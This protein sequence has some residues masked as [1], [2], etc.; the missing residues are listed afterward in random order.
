VAL[1]YSVPIIQLFRV[2]AETQVELIAILLL[3]IPRFAGYLYFSYLG[4]KDISRLEGRRRVVLLGMAVFSAYLLLSG[5]LAVYHYLIHPEHLMVAKKFAVAI[6]F[7][8]KTRIGLSR[9]AFTLN[10]F[11]LAGIFLYN[12]A[13]FTIKGF[14]IENQLRMMCSLLIAIG[15][16]NILIVS[17]VFTPFVG[18]LAL[19]LALW[20]RE[21]GYKLAFLQA[22]LLALTS[23]GIGSGVFLLRDFFSPGG[24]ERVFMYAMACCLVVGVISLVGYI[25]I[26][27]R[28]YSRLGKRNEYRAR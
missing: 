14:T 10:S 8:E 12:I 16:A 6:P 27:K 18:F 11:V 23:A 25:A 2:R 20:T 28:F 21:K 15:M 3:V 7:A 1:V 22:I 9:L 26:R 5:A 13:R 4:L 24:M 19:F 17:F